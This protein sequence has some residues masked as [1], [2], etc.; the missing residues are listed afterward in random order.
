MVERAGELVLGWV[1]DGEGVPELDRVE[2]GG[3]A[4]RGVIKVRVGGGGVDWEVRVGEEVRD[5]VGDVRG[6][7]V[8]VV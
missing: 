4:R 6:R 1:V 5:E 2:K 3:E 7:D 8:D